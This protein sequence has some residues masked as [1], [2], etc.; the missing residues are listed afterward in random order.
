MADTETAEIRI[1]YSIETPHGVFTDAF[2][3]SIDEYAKL[4]QDDL[5]AM[6]QE[7][8][9]NWL[10]AMNRPPPTKADLEA[11]AASLDEEQAGIEE[12]KQ[13]ALQRAAALVATET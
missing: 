8:V 1:R 3:F 5:E 2:T 12:R 9:N 13:E 11:L 4:S 10:A 7:R 6:K